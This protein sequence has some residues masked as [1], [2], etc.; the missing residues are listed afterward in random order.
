MWARCGGRPSLVSIWKRHRA[1]GCVKK[2]GLCMRADSLWACTGCKKHTRVQAGRRGVEG[3]SMRES[4]QGK[5][6]HLAVECTNASGGDSHPWAEHHGPRGRSNCWEAVRW[7][8]RVGP[9]SGA[10]PK[11]FP[12][13]HGDA[14]EAASALCAVPGGG[15]GVSGG[16]GTRPCRG[17]TGA[18]L[19]PADLERRS[20]HQHALRGRRKG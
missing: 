18:V 12:S 11:Q 5:R 2:C 14:G 20:D 9:P 10:P 4:P 15:R 13:P 19:G 6:A 16:G 3:A 8:A 1:C 17:G 7:G